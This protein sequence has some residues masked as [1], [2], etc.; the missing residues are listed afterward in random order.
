[1]KTLSLGDDFMLQES[2][3]PTAPRKAINDVLPALINGKG[4]PVG[5][6]EPVTTGY[7]IEVLFKLRQYQN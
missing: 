7:Y 5:G 3:I 4:K 2:S 1:M 6:I